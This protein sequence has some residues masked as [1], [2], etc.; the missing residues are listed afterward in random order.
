MSQYLDS[1]EIGDYVDIRGPSGKLTY[2]GRGEFSL[3]IKHAIFHRYT[4]VSLIPS[5]LKPPPPPPPFDE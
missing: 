3:E 1:L 2:L 4:D 5:C